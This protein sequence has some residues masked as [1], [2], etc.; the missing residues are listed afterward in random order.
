MRVV[1]AW[2]AAEGWPA[3]IRD[4]EP[5]DDPKETHGICLTHQERLQTVLRGSAR[6]SL[7]RRG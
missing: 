2:C 6:G 7:C 4:K 1:C 3:F 5:G